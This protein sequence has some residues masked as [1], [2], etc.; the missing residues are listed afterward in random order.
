[1]PLR[2]NILPKEKA[3]NRK[4]QRK[5]ENQE[6][7]EDLQLEMTISVNKIRRYDSTQNIPN[8]SNFMIC[9]YGFSQQ[10]NSL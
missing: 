1:M 7:Y 9:F 2:K 10:G 3:T 4:F 8:E 5:L 6:E